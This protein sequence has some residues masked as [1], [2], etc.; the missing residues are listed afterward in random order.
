[1]GIR[2]TGKGF[3]LLFGIAFFWAVV[4]GNGLGSE[5]EPIIVAQYSI[6]GAR[7]PYSNLVKENNLFNYFGPGVIT[8]NGQRQMYSLGK[9]MST[10]KYK[11]LIEV[12]KQ[13]ENFKIYSPSIERC[14]LSAQALHLGLAGFDVPYKVETDN[15]EVLMPPFSGFLAPTINYE[16]ALP[17]GI[18]PSPVISTN[19]TADTLFLSNF[20]TICPLGY[21]KML[22]YQRNNT[23][24][25]E[26]RMTA[27]FDALEKN[28]TKDGIWELLNLKVQRLDIR[29]C[30][31]ISDELTSFF[32]YNGAIVSGFENYWQKLK[33]FDMLYY[34]NSVPPEMDIL[35]TTNAGKMMIKEF[36]LKIE[37][38]DK[39][40]I[41]SVDNH[42]KYLGF[43]SHHLNIVLLLRIL[44]QT[45]AECI[46]EAILNDFTIPE[47]KVCEL[48]PSFASNLIVELLV[49]KQ[50][51]SGTSSSKTTSLKPE[52]EFYV[53]ATFNGRPIDL[54]DVF[55]PPYAPKH[56]GN[57]SF[58]NFKKLASSE[59]VENKFDELC[60]GT[61]ELA[62]V[63]AFW[64]VLGIM[65]AVIIGLS[66]MVIRLYLQSRRIAD[67]KTYEL[68]EET[69][70]AIDI[71][72]SKSR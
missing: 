38:L 11:D 49:V 65:I 58:E 60:K 39:D 55:T 67:K 19:E 36:A 12:N 5:V 1:M 57:C 15:K 43:V 2:C 4:L 27:V 16:S 46:I 40:K 17:N 51:D 42:L 72:I 23:I 37:D 64:I 7:S 9:F 28:F 34:L 6:S 13:P 48:I 3:R 69:E 14:T 62:R 52:L 31:Q 41:T 8:P 29:S 71:S 30:H 54:C 20:S 61:K 53:N 56:Q 18:L 59:L 66:V 35:Y 33:F 10:I 26:N 63:V 70:A 45:S 24:K 21:R 47:N 25:V 68:A 44:K 22:D 50:D 32:Y